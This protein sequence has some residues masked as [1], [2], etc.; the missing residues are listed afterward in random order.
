MIHDVK[1]F[2]RIIIWVLK[3]GKNRI[4]GMVGKRGEIESNILI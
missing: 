4:S 1:Y 3:N 2:A